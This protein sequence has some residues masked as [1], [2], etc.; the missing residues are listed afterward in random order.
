MLFVKP[1]KNKKVPAVILSAGSEI[2]TISIAQALIKHHIPIILISFGRKSILWDIPQVLWYYQ[3]SWPPIDSNQCAEDILNWLKNCH[4]SLTTIRF[5][6]FPTDDSGLRFILEHRNAFQKV[7]HIPLT[8]R[9]KM[10]GLDKAEFFYFLKHTASKSY[11]VET[12]ILNGFDSAINAFQ[13]LGNDVVFKPALKPLSMNLKPMDSKVITAF[14]Q[15]DS[16]FSVLKKLEK[17][18]HHSSIWIAQKRLNV[19]VQGEQSWVGIRTK[20]KET[21]GL[22]VVERRKYPKMGGSAC[23]AQ[24]ID[25]SEVEIQARQILNDLDYCGIFEISFLLNHKNQWVALEFNPR[26]WLQTGLVEA[27]GF[28]LIWTTYCDMLNMDI[29]YENLS[30]KKQVHWVNPERLILSAISGE[31]GPKIPGFI[32]ALKII[33]KSEYMTIYQSQ[34]KTMIY[35]WLKRMICNALDLIGKKIYA[36]KKR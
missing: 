29:N 32:H 30:I 16:Q 8:S 3:V 21:F 33:H 10:C 7:F 24:S 1:M 20:K 6:V 18:W 31:Y 23:W 4:L 35:R 25:S 13:L 28:P 27:S 36:N 19:P 14:N 2:V 26:P 5:P 15:Q 34:S 11:L 22:T 9:L 17:A 12:L